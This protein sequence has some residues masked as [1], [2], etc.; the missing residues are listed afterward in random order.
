MDQITKDSLHSSIKKMQFFMDEG[1]PLVM[2]CSGTENL[3]EDCLITVE[4]RETSIEY[5]SVEEESLQFD[6]F[7]VLFESFCNHQIFKMLNLAIPL[8]LVKQRE[9]SQKYFS[10]LPFN[11]NL[12]HSDLVRILGATNF[13]RWELFSGSPGTFRKIFSSRIQTDSCKKMFMAL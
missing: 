8:T 3:F 9:K 1:Y 12:N 10:L 4:R 2:Y 6:Q 13:A 5:C 11:W 7:L